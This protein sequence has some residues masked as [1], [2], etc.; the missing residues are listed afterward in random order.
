MCIFQSNSLSRVRYANRWRRTYKWNTARG[1]VDPVP[2]RICHE[3][4]ETSNA[5]ARKHD[6]FRFGRDP[7]DTGAMR[8]FI[9]EKEARAINASDKITTR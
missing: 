8:I 3:I 1:D 5:L 2:G 9:V 6:R 4:F 7:Q